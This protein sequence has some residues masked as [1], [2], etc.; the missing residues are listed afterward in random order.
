MH[1][2]HNPD[3]VAAAAAWVLGQTSLQPRLGIV[4]GSGLGAFAE[5]LQDAQRIPYGDIPHFARV[6]VPGHKGELVL[7]MLHG[8]PIAV[9]NGRVHHYEGHD[10]AHVTL[11]VRVLGALGVKQLVVTNA[12]GGLNPHYAPGTLMVIEDHINLT[13]SHPLR[14]PVGPKDGPRFVDMTTAY[15]VAGRTAWHEAARTV[16]VALRAGVYVGVSGPSYETPAEVRMMQRLG[17]DAVGMS[18]VFE[19][20]TARQIGLEVAGLSVICNAGAGMGM[21]HLAHEDVT[22]VATQ[23]REVTCQ[24]LT[25]MVRA[26]A[27]QGPSSAADA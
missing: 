8:V 18:T 1:K 2:S 15:S 21:G 13:G 16:G 22:H 20:L 11:P 17:G 25:H 19:V 9:M 6:H 5:T 10:L 27:S 3:D 7:G 26:W 4:L 12:A 23:M 24:L 14:G